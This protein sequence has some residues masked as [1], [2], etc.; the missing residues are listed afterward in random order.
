M[1]NDDS[2]TGEVKAMFAMQAVQALRAQ[3]VLFGIECYNVK[4]ANVIIKRKRSS[5]GIAVP[6][7]YGSVIVAGQPRSSHSH[8]MATLAYMLPE[9]VLINSQLSKAQAHI[10]PVCCCLRPH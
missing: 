3:S 9:V 7:D 10:R 8:G 2:V 5:V 1:L 6:I 4:A